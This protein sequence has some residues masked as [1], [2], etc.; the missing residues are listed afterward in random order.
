MK[1]LFLTAF[2]GV[3]LISAC[4]DAHEHDEPAEHAQDEHLDEHGHGHE[5]AIGQT[6]IA[7]EAAKAAGVVTEQAGPAE[8]RETL[9]L[10]GTVVPD[11]QRVHRIRPR[12]AGVVKEVRRRVGDPVKTGEVVA[13]VE[14]SESLQRYSIAAPG[15]GIVVS[16]D[17]NPGVPVDDDVLLTIVDLSS[18]W[19]E[20]AAFTHDLDH[21]KVGQEVTVTDVDG[22]RATEGRI[23]SIAAVGSPA[24][25]SM[26]VRVLLPNGEGHW[27]PGLFAA[28]EVTISRTRVPVAVRRVAVQDL[29]GRAVVF[30]QHGEAYEA[31]AVEL[32]Q[33]DAQWAEVKA[34]IGVGDTYVVGNSFL[35]KADIEKS[36][37]SHD[38]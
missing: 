35:I 32:G 5:E 25:Q 6:S 10:H 17:V 34:G 38:H 16:R 24:S 7:P 29:G 27:R 12:F 15:A 22:H 36:G 9:S 13:V 37:A 20:F 30:E 18:V 2:A 21:L 14:A 11:P 1:N 19:V 33:S 4:S 31:R 23:E 8:I 28:G 26:T 3:M